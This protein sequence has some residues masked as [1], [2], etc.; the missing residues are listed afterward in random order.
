[1]LDWENLTITKALKEA[2]E[3]WGNREGDAENTE[4]SS[5]E[6]KK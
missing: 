5:Q 1:M 4:S 2:S 3:K 6:R